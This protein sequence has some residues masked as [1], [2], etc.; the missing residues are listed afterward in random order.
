MS[1]AAWYV[2]H[3][4][5]QEEA[6]AA[7]HLDRQGFEVFLPR[8]VVRTRR[9]RRE[10]V[11]FFPRY[12][13]VRVRRG[14]EWGC[15][16]HTRGVADVLMAGPMRPAVVADP[17]IEEIRARADG[18]GVVDLTRPARFEKGARLRIVEGLFAGFEGL[19]LCSARGRAKILLDNCG[20]GDVV[21]IPVD[22]L[23][24]T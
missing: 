15:V 10:V 18:E 13:F 6:R 11:P 22:H 20:R 3:S 17:V 7:V 16:L 21:A 5:W 4:H 14:Q 2:V 24:A 1:E 12:L 19:Y 8:C 9:R 23:A